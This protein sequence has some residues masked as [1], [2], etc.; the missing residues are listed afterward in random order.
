MSDLK[1]TQIP[2]DSIWNKK[3]VAVLLTV[4][5]FSLIM[6]CLYLLGGDSKDPET[7]YQAKRLEFCEAEKGNAH[8]K[9]LEHIEYPSQ[10]PLTN[11]RLVELDQKQSKSCDDQSIIPVA[12]ALSF[13]TLSF[14]N[15]DNGSSYKN[16]GNSNNNMQL[17]YN[18]LSDH[19]ITQKKEIEKHPVFHGSPQQQEYIDYAWNTYH[20]KNLIYLMKAENGLITPDRKHDLSYWC[21][22]RKTWGN[23]WGFG[24]ISD[25]HHREITSDPRFFTDWKWQI[26]QVYKLYKGGTTFTSRPNWASMAQYFDWI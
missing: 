14:N 2:M 7:V 17:L 21:K 18:N 19:Q 16:I 22:K 6:G 20:D 23:D 11:E 5:L 15:Q 26:D 9:I 3:W 24:G 10:Y 8:K 25:C 12:K 4:G 1:Q 13:D